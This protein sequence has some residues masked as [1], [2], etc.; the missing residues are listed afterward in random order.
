MSGID[1]LLRLLN[2]YPP[3]TTIGEVVDEIFSGIP[4]PV[5]THV[6]EIK[7]RFGTSKPA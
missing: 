7:L 5:R 6:T 2:T 4:Q 3:E 1:D